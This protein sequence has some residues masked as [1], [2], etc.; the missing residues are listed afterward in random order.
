MSGKR[1]DS[2]SERH[3]QYQKKRSELIGLGRKKWVTKAYFPNVEDGSGRGG[4][5]I[6]SIP[7][8]GRT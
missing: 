4:K 5:E 3:G 8:K 7:T 1:I 6:R 2:V